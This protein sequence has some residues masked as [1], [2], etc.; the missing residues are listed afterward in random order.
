[1]R[2]KK[3]PL[4]L[5]NPIAME[6]INGYFGQCA[7]TIYYHSDG[8]NSNSSLDINYTLIIIVKSLVFT[9]NRK[10]ME[11]VCPKSIIII[12]FNMG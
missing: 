5:G 3:L 7:L 2:P 10:M 9:G 11:I 8:M 6:N 12:I 4:T 1:M